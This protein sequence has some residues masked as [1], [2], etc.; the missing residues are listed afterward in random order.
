[1]T[2]EI[3]NWLLEGRTT[4]CEHTRAHSGYQRGASPSRLYF[5]GALGAWEGSK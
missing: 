1:M 2:S 5:H 4:E 3:S